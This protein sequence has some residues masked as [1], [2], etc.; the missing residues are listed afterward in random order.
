M[1]FSKLSSLLL[2]AFVLTAPPSLDLSIASEAVAM[3]SRRARRGK[4][5][6]RLKRKSKTS[7]KNLLGSRA[8]RRS[9][10]QSL[11]S[12]QSSGRA[13]AKQIFVAPKSPRETAR[14]LKVKTRAEAKLWSRLKELDLIGPILRNSDSSG[15]PRYAKEKELL[16]SSATF[17]SLYPKVKLYGKIRVRRNGEAFLDIHAKFQPQEGLRIEGNYSPLS[18]HYTKT[19]ISYF[20]SKNGMPAIYEK[21]NSAMRLARGK[22]AERAKEPNPNN[23]AWD[24]AAEQIWD[25]LSPK[26]R[27]DITDALFAEAVQEMYLGPQDGMGEIQRAQRQFIVNYQIARRE[28]RLRS[29]LHGEYAGLFVEVA[30]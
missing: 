12:L 3:K 2:L 8:R 10:R 14:L 30:K 20:V 5:K 6:A 9:K 1:F 16:D 24:S 26:E 23:D 21:F 29:R 7:K 19:M 27:Q 13:L 17:E 25:V 18:D 28:N 22:E 4:K 15:A 11:R